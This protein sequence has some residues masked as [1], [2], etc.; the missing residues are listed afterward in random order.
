MFVTAVAGAQFYSLLN[1]WPLECQTFFGPSPHAIART[2]IP[3]GFSVALGVIIVNWGLSILHG[4]NRELLVLSSC[5]MTAGIG[6]LAAV[7]PTRRAL[8]IGVSVLGGFGVG[9]IIIPAAIILTIIS[10]D[11]V[12]ATV[13]ALNLSARLIGGSIGYAIYYNIFENKLAA[14]L[15]ATVG[16]AAAGAG[17]PL[18]E[19]PALVGA[20]VAKNITAIALLPGI[21]PAII[22]AAEVAVEG[23][24]VEAFKRVYLVSIAFGGSA[25]LA[26]LFV[27]DIRKYMVGRVA[28]EYAGWG[29]WDKKPAQQS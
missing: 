6:A 11:E 19:I 3:F 25:V 26:S 13:T 15:P 16:A 23:S 29:N 17:L 1:F 2:V 27:G 20:L 24:F 28:V 10:P 5:M 21:T 9:G 7:T 14:V 12:I 8:G 18:A 22:Q 4:A